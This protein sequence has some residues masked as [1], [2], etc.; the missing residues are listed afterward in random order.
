MTEKNSLSSPEKNEKKGFWS[1]IIKT[2]NHTDNDADSL[3]TEEKLTAENKNTNTSEDETLKSTNQP[4]K[5]GFPGKPFDRNNP[6][7][8]GFLAASGALI[9]FIVYTQLGKLTETLIWIVTAAFIS[10]GLE[11]IVQKLMSKGL[12]RGLSLG[13]VL[14]SLLIV[15]GVFFSILVPTIIN[16]I[17]QLVEHMPTY[18]QSMLNSSWFHDLD[19]R[20]SIRQNIENNAEKL[21]NEFTS[22]AG[23]LAGTLVG[24]G[25]AVSHILLSTF[26]ILIF[27][28]YFLIS[29]PAFKAF[30]YR[31]APAS[32]RERFKVLSEEVIQ[33][34][35]GYVTGQATI[36]IINATVAG[37]LMTILHIPFR[38]LLIS[39]VAI[40]AFIPLIGPT[41]ALITVTSI[42]L[43]LGWQIAL[44]YAICYLIYLQL[45]GYVLSPIVMKKVVEV[46]PVVSIVSIV[47]GG[48]L[49]GVLGAVIAIPTAAAA[50]LF[51]REVII[52]RQDQQ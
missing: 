37:T 47:I 32:R 2:K 4:H 51:F 48:N 17:T 27:T 9:A 45:E 5:F 13:I 11:P 18:V 12:K 28:V 29:M 44:I 39:L 46:P 22:S 26:M 41:I 52:P 43:T 30:M 42:A 35:G 24:A 8:F 15:F 21:I 1:G 50:Q 23:S 19:H 49:L 33:G 6:I 25:A 31:I 10:L 14:F 20:F 16:Q 3:K 40:F 38:A 36:A 34:V 7:R